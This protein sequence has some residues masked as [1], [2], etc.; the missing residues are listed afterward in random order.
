MFQT[1]IKIV[2]EKIFQ[3]ETFLAWNYT[4]IFLILIKTK[5]QFVK[6]ETR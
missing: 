4:I 5:V 6:T 1:I 2:N 3:K